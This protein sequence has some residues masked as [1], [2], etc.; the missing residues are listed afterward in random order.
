MVGRGDGV[1]FVDYRGNLVG[2]AVAPAVIVDGFASRVDRLDRL[3]T[4]GELVTVVELGLQ[5]GPEALAL[6]IVPARP[7]S[8]RAKALSGTPDSP[9][10]AI[11]HHTSDVTATRRSLTLS[12]PP[13]RGHTLLPGTPC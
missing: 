8:V 11:N 12:S 2:N 9:A 6:G 10:A 4:G 1:V 13:P 3:H 7:W 5:G